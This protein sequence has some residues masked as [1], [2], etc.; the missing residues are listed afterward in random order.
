MREEE[1]ISGFI[2]SFGVIERTIASIWDIS[3]GS[4]L[5]LLRSTL[6]I[7]GI[8]FIMFSSGP[9]F[10]ICFILDKKSS[11][12][13]TDF[14]SVIIGDKVCFGKFEQD[15]LLTDGAEDIVWIVIAKEDG[16]TL[17]LSEKILYLMPFDDDTGDWE[18]S[19]IRKWLNNDFYTFFSSKESKMIIL[20]NLK[21]IQPIMNLI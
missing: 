16:R 10:F 17:L 21:S 13:T 8:N 2:L 4:I 14:E 19:D 11:K 18:T 12:S 6:G 9:S 3:F 7:P 1:T 15:G 5:A 20:S